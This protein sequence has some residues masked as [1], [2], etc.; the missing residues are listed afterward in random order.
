MGQEAELAEE[1]VVHHVQSVPCAVH[2]V[3]F[4]L[5]TGNALVQLVCVTHI[6]CAALSPGQVLSLCQVLFLVATSRS[7]LF[8]SR[9]P[10]PISF[11]AG[12]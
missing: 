5:R 9:V 6:V 2:N 3:S 1:R 10:G 11:A 12:L 8:Y 4:L 7:H